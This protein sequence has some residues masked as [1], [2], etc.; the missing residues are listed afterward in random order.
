MQPES[1][2]NKDPIKEG[3]ADFAL[4][5]SIDCVALYMQESDTYLN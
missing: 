5:R 2:H 1:V 3:M 4:E